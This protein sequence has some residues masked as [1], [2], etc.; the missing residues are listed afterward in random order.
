[1]LHLQAVA[2][3]TSAKTV[4]KWFHGSTLREHG[5][6]VRRDPGKGEIRVQGRQIGV[7]GRAGIG[8]PLKTGPVGGQEN[9]ASIAGFAEAGAGRRKRMAAEA[10]LAVGER[11][12]AIGEQR[13]QLLAAIKAMFQRMRAGRLGDGHGV[14]WFRRGLHFGG[15]G[16]CG[17]LRRQAGWCGGLAGSFRDQSGFLCSL[18]QNWRINGALPRRLYESVSAGGAVVAGQRLRIASGAV[19]RAGVAAA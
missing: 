8:V 7:T 11:A 9:A 19:R 2:D 4:Q 12:L 6:L 17:G 10:V 5:S 1:V 3:G 16:C 18:G 13:R 15:C 14:R